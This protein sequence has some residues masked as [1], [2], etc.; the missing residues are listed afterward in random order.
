MNELR[1]PIF[2]KLLAVVIFGIALAYFEA[3]VVVYLRAIFYP[4][5]FK[6]PLSLFDINASHKHLLL[7]EIGREAATV[8][9]IVCSCWIFG[10]NR[11]QR[12]AG[13]FIIFAVWDIF[14]LKLRLSFP[15]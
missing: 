3:A 2:L 1:K 13:F 8:V 14:Y 4:E 11:R 5:G 6:F 7:T 10:H 12:L 9:L 15:D